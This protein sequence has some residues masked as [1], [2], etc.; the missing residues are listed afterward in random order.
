MAQGHAV[1]GDRT[2]LR[3]SLRIAQDSRALLRYVLV[4]VVRDGQFVRSLRWVECGR[5][6]VPFS[7]HGAH[8]MTTICFSCLCSLFRF[9][10]FRVRPLH[11]WIPREAKRKTTTRFLMLGIEPISPGD[12]HP[13]NRWC[14]KGLLEKTRSALEPVARAVGMHHT[15]A[16]FSVRPLVQRRSS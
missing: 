16:R 12:Q 7:D 11:Q 4:S 13:Y 9:P 6:A 14:P 3:H 5:F 8:R 1:P 10:S 2:S 15:V